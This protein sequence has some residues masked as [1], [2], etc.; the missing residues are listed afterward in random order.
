MQ[1]VS[2]SEF[3]PAVHG[4]PLFQPNPGPQ[5]ELFTR[6]ETE[7]C[8]GGSK[9]G[10]KSYAAAAWLVW[11]NQAWGIPAQ[12]P[13]T[14][15]VDLVNISYIHHP[16][17]RA[18]VLRKNAVDMRTWIAKA[19]TI[20]RKL[21]AKLVTSGITRFVFPSGATIVI[22]HLADKMAWEK[23]A[24]QE[25]HRIVIEELTQIPDEETY[26]LAVTSCLRSVHPELRTQVLSTCNPGGP[27]HGWVRKRFV[28][29]HDQEGNRIPEGMSIVDPESGMD[30]VF[31]RA[32]LTDN[33]YLMQNQRYYNLLKMLPMKL[34]RAMLYGDWDVLEGQFF[35]EFRPEGPIGKEPPWARHV[36]EPVPLPVWSRRWIGGDYGYNHP[37]A[38][39]WFGRAK[40][41]RVHVYREMVHS[42]WGGYKLGVKLAEMSL[43]DLTTAHTK[44][45][46]LFLGGDTWNKRDAGPTPVDAMAEGIRKVLGDKGCLLRNAK[47][48]GTAQEDRANLMEELSEPLEP[49]KAKI[50]ITPAYRDRVAG[51][52][53]LHE[54]LRWEEAITVDQSGYD[55]RYAKELKLKDP[56]G[57]LFREYWDSYF[58]VEQE[59]LPKMLIH[60]NCERLIDR[61]PEMMHDDN[62]PEDMKKVDGDDEVDAWRY[63][64]YSQYLVDA[65]LPEAVF[66]REE[67]NQMMSETPMDPTD[68]QHVN[69]ALRQRY[70]QQRKKPVQRFTIPPAGPAIQGAMYA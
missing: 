64:A 63:G 70:Q 44:T 14:G 42:K 31:I 46:A 28:R 36:I 60:R 43:P 30:R 48:G 7:I 29:P 17:Y 6:T 45:M 37:A 53:Y 58:D 69:A 13:V 19:A 9:G 8:Y 33:P 22:S 59:T 24:G 27:G 49:G 67:L 38:F 15:K 41:T 12:D 21:G 34:R 10:G 52:A 3:D 2:A 23:Y 26:L 25:F 35:H 68:W 57:K 4:K 55:P 1:F 11:G 20:Y 16:D 40:D 62:N 51:A 32:R 65:E 56:S 47:R 54:M 39:Y 66:V 18:L 5:S 61:I 50:V